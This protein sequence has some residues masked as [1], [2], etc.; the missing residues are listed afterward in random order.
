MK[1]LKATKQKLNSY[2]KKE[3]KKEV[4]NQEQKDKTIQNINNKTFT[5]EKCN[6]TYDTESGLWKHNK[7][8]SQ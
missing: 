8:I 4:I 2:I 6:K 5:C 7:K 1:H 3:Q